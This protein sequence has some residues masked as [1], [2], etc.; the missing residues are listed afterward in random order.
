[1]RSYIAAMCGWFSEANT[2]KLL[3][4]GFH[5]SRDR[6]VAVRKTPVRTVGVDLIAFSLSFL[7]TGRKDNAAA[8]RVGFHGVGERGGVRE[9]E[10]GLEHFD[11]VLKRVVVVIQ[12]DDVI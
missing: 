9:A 7:Q 3:L 5:Q 11:H 8:G 2:L 4:R 12:N 6:S 1:M 10:N